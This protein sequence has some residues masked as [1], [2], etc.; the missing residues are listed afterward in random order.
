MAPPACPTGCAEGVILHI[1]LPD[2][3]GKR[4]RALAFRTVDQAEQVAGF[5]QRLLVSALQK[6]VAISSEAVKFLPQACERYHSD[7][8]VQLRLTENEGQHGDEQVALGDGEQFRSVG[9]AA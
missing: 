2:R 9:G 3:S 4:H 7:A 5:V 6:D 1:D 8:A